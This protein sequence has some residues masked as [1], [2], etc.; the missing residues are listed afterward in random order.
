MCSFAMIVLRIYQ[1][2]IGLRTIQPT[3]SILRAKEKQT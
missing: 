3:L 2:F 1:C